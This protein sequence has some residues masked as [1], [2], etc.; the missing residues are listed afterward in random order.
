[1]NKVK[2]YVDK[3][4]KVDSLEEVC[5]KEYPRPS[6]RRDSYLCL[7]GFYEACITKEDK[8]PTSFPLKVRVPFAIES[9]A[10]L[11]NKTL[12][13]DEY[14]FY[15]KHVILEDGFIKDKVFLNFDGVDQIATIYIDNEE[16]MT[17]VGGYT[18]FSVDVT[19]Y[20]KEFDLVVKVQDLND[21]SYH[22]RGKQVSSPNGWFYSAS[23]GIYKPVWL[24]STSSN[25]IK[26][27]KFIT[28]F[29][30]KE[31]KVIITTDEVEEARV[32]ILDKEYKFNTITPYSIK[33]DE[34]KAWSPSSPYL[35]EVNIKLKEDEVD[36]YFAFRKIEIR[37]VN[38]VKR[39]YLNNEPIFLNGLLDQGYYFIGNLT[40]LS[41][42]D[43]L[44]DIK[45]IK[46]L[47]YNTLRKH[48]KIECDMFYYYAD[49]EG[50][51][52]IQDF[53][54]GG[55]PYKFLNV[56]LPR[57]FASLNDEKHTSY[58]KLSREDELGRE[59]FKNEAFYYLNSL[60][61]HPSIVVY[62]IFNEGW[63]Q[64]DSSY[65]YSILKEKDPSRLYDTASG[66]YEAYRSDFYSLHTYS[67]PNMKRKNKHNRAY[68]M[69]EIGGA[70]LK[71]DNHSYFEGIFGHHLCKDEEKLTRYYKDLYL[72]TVVSHI[73]NRGLI[74]SIYTQ[75]A[76][77]EAEYNGIYSFDRE[78]LKIDSETIK[79]INRKIY[80][81]YSSV[82]KK[83]QL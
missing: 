63:G 49:K 70:A 60:Y 54:C 78:V 24:E 14:L 5:L 59:E 68:L 9:E 44:K 17:H 3:N 56:V 42:E 33:F 35:Y 16:V 83:T 53:P 18:K 37:E 23:S 11:V 67:F 55:T 39:V 62:T 73:K 19:K 32:T 30:N 27:V 34:I 81:V 76:D 80:E 7:N 45:N 28:D 40:P 69:S 47:G 1:M 65:F 26:D 51:L 12:E 15:R 13:K 46:E 43:Y 10:S 79:E 31:V 52:L 38:S 6:L 41:Y 25:Y 8:I 50:V 82:V 77:C 72:N 20:G 4:R 36:T 74:G 66:W 2:Y 64:F 71:V 57:L 21:T 61:N 29:D 75:I 22:S 48:I 58:K